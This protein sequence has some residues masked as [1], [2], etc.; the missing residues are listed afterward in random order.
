MNAYLPEGMGWH[1]HALPPEL[2]HAAE[3]DGRIL[4]ANAVMCD[5]KH[6]LWVDLG[7]RHGRIPR[8]E[9]ALGIADGTT[10][11]I[12]ILSRVGKPVCFQVLG[13]AADGTPRLSRRAAQEKAL[14]HLLTR[15]PGDILPAVVTSCAPF[16]A[17]CDAGCGIPALLGRENIC[18]A[19]ICHA[20]E[21]FTEGQA[22]YAAIQSVDPLRRRITL[23]HKEL[24]GTWA[25]N[26]A[27]FRQG[28]TVTGV[29]R[30]LHDYGIFVELSPNLSG[31]ADLYPGVQPGDHVSVYI[32]SI[33]PERQK[34]KLS[35]LSRLSAPPA[36]KPFRYF[37]TSGSVSG[38]SYHGA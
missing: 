14:S 25:E 24:L 37:K 35:I 31:L 23:T 29:V 26:A 7:G 36:K 22:I 13:F 33:Q 38:W 18:A 10:R 21:V 5:E 17:F 4:Q 19:R 3:A 32:K 30:G 1:A 16:G 20:S 2:L 9:A 11:D 27:C 34:L 8:A 6:D 12:A 28:Q 15:T